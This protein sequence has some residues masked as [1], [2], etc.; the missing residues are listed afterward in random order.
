LIERVSEIREF[1]IRD[2]QGG[3]R[4]GK[5]VWIRE[6]KGCVCCVMDLEE[7]HDR[8]DMMVMWEVLGMYGV[9]GEILSAIKIMCEDIDHGG[10]KNRS[11]AGEEV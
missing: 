10:C 6:A 4:R 8:V 2:E 1:Q 9:G 11:K 5:V 7:A 3:F